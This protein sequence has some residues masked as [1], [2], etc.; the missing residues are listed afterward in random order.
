M[1]I[2][3]KSFGIKPIIQNSMRLIRLFM[4]ICFNIHLFITNKF[5]RKYRYVV[6]QP[7]GFHV[8]AQIISVELI[9]L[10]TIITMF[11]VMKSSVDWEI[12]WLWSGN[13]GLNSHENQ[14]KVRGVFLL[15][16]FSVVG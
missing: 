9:F 12:S 8:C 2:K 10:V 15:L 14:G 7:P 3:L 5:E 4:Y 6:F 13:L 11:E 16:F 1:G